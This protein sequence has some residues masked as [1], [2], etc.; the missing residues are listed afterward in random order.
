M[1]QSDTSLKD[2]CC[3]GGSPQG[4]PDMRKKTAHRTDS[5]LRSVVAVK[6]SLKKK[7]GGWRVEFR[8]FLATRYQEV[9]H[10]EARQQTA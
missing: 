1:Q 7:S 6:K 3:G 5:D 9:N 4:C 10:N 8:P 2:F